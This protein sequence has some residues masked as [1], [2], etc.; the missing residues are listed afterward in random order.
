MADRTRWCVITGAPCAGKTSVIR[1]LENRGFRVVHEAARAYIDAQLARG[2]DMAGIRSDTLAFEQAILERKIR[3]E[4][5][6]PRDK[7]IFLDRAVPDSIAYY[8]AE[9]LDPA[10]PRR[11]SRTRRYRRVF[12]FDPLPFKT[13][14][15]RTE[16]DRRAR[17]LHAFITA[18]YRDLGYDTIRVPV[19]PVSRRTDFLLA[20]LDGHPRIAPAT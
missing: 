16:T 18:C 19:M 20:R 3:I 17:Q 8:L 1:A 5:A 2:G 15:I 12:V 13:D 9:G 6:L 10:V 11:Y 7:P 4:A 14:R